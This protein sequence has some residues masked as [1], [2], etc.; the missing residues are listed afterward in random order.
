LKNENKSLKAGLGSKKEKENNAGLDLKKKGESDLKKET[1]DASDLFTN[2]LGPNT[3]NIN[4]NKTAA[5]TAN[6]TG[7]FIAEQTI[8]KL[9]QKISSHERTQKDLLSQLQTLT[10]KTESTS[11]LL[12]DLKISKT[13]MQ[14]EI[15][16]LGDDNERL[17]EA[18][19]FFEQELKGLNE[20]LKGVCMDR[21][22]VKELY[23]QVFGG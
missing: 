20:Q 10:L 12:T 22:A 1:K 6:N 4:A 13:N 3:T 21:D 8:I 23:R 15:N 17:L 18:L 14:K 2:P 5:S 19:E 9:N 11:H 16:R 7:L